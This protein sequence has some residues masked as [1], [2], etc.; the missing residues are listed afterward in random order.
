MARTI[1]KQDS[2]TKR[3]IRNNE[4]TPGLS[5]ETKRLNYHVIIVIEMVPLPSQVNSM[6]IY[7]THT[8]ISEMIIFYNWVTRISI[9]ETAYT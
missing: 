4:Q 1:R 3:C 2:V 5:V 9:K 8:N 7:L 6:Q